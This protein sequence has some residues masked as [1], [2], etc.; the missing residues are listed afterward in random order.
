MLIQI[1]HKIRGDVYS[2]LKIYDKKIIKY[3]EPVIL[4][5]KIIIDKTSIMND[6]LYKASKIDSDYF[7]VFIVVSL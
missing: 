4:D 7:I 2:K 3:F 5:S 6:F 1:G